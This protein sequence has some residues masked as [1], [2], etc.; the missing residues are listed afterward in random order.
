[1]TKPLRRLAPWARR[2]VQAGS[3]F[4]FLLLLITAGRGA[5]SSIHGLYFHLDPLLAL[6]AWLA[7]GASAPAFLLALLPLALTLVLGRFFCGWLCPFGVLHRVFTFLGR[8]G[9]VEAPPPGRSLRRIKYLVLAVVVTS[10]V[11]GAELAGLIDPIA[12]LARSTAV[13]LAPLARHVASVSS[14]RLGVELVGL[15]LLALLFAN[16]WRR[17]FFC[18][19]L[20]PLGALYA[21]LARWSPTA[22]RATSSCSDCAQ[23]N[24]PCP[25]GGGP[26]GAAPKK[27]CF[28]C[29]DCLASCP[30][31]AVALGAAAPFSAP[32]A[33]F[34][35]GRRSL[36][37]SMA[38]GTLL[39]GL[40][41]VSAAAP[42]NARPFV[43][44]PGALSEP[45]FLERCLR[46]GLCIEACPTSFV[47]A[48]ALE[49]GFEGL[50][51]PIVDARVGSCDYE[52]T[53]CLSACPSG[54]LA[55]LDLTDKKVFKIGSAVVEPARCLTYSAAL[56]CTRCAEACPIP[57]G[58]IRFHGAQGLDERGRL[59][60][61]QRITVRQDLCNGCGA[62]VNA[63]PRTDQ[64][65]IRITADDESREGG[66]GTW[67]QH[68]RASM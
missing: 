23:C 39:A 54:A 58:A 59:V 7:D 47:Q 21:I 56:A 46:C 36:L 11:L 35:A 17:H 10:T 22:V 41:A 61:V 34:D 32:A 40:P 26:I 12:L 2:L 68:A 45:R 66:F 51:T 6:Q 42:S 24:G 63:C 20:C 53:R 9:G 37:G 14:P 29:L 38:A 8:R 44:P 57:E 13:A 1:M 65:G 55:K 15:L 60:D 49:A 27:D 48:A 4:S 64:P 19:T 18:H 28:V 16:F 43:R 33:P 5:G 52:C 67:P 62:C 50:W 3:L 31:D 25:H 30:M